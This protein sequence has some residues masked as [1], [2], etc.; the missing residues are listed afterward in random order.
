MIL[1]EK[2][3]TCL[4]NDMLPFSWSLISWSFYDAVASEFL[5]SSKYR[6]TSDLSLFIEARC[7]SCSFIQHCFL[8]FSENCTQRIPVQGRYTYSIVASP[9][10]AVS[11]QATVLHSCEV[12][13]GTVVYVCLHWLCLYCRT[14]TPVS[15][16]F[17]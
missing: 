4:R 17:T 5:L 6:G 13:V 11:A 10:S 2:G 3:V 9:W 8:L 12:P 7:Q 1:K 16:R 14:T 15:W